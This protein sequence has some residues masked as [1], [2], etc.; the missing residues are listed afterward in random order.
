MKKIILTLLIMTLS[1]VGF[2]QVQ[3][4][5]M[6][7]KTKIGNITLKNGTQ[8]EMTFKTESCDCPGVKEGDENTVI[9]KDTTMVNW[10]IYDLEQSIY[11]I[12]KN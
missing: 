1:I 11:T 12:E 9:L 6:N 2:S 7:R 4:R 3:S 10:F 5:P 8:I